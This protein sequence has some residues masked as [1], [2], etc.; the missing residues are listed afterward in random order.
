MSG[1]FEFA[2]LGISVSNPAFRRRA[3]DAFRRAETTHSITLG[4]IHFEERMS[5]GRRLA[6]AWAKVIGNAASG[7]QQHRAPGR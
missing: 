1:I 6:I 2:D 7:G 5:D 3:H 4:P